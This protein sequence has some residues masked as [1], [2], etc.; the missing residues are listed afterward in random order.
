MDMKVFK[1]RDYYFNY[2][3]NA[4]GVACSILL[5]RRDMFGRR[6]LKQKYK[7]ARESYIGELT[8]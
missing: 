2:M 8:F 7:V 5:I 4:D 3:I 6:I 1:A